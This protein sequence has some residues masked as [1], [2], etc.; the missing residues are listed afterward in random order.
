M[1]RPADD[2]LA[3]LAPA[4][5]RQSVGAEPEGGV[6]RC[7]EDRRTAAGAFAC[8]AAPPRLTR[9]SEWWEPRLRREQRR[10]PSKSSCMHNVVA[11]IST[12]AAQPLPAVSAPAQAASSP[13]LP[14]DAPQGPVIAQT[15]QPIINLPAP[16]KLEW[17]ELQGVWPSIAAVI[18]VVLTGISLHCSA[19]L[20][21]VD[22]TRWLSSPS[23][24]AVSSGAPPLVVRL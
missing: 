5:G 7:G 3:A 19:S 17:Y 16:Q 13:A 22:A 14:A 6:D 12:A 10:P 20:R 21:G 15:I 11:M 4:E 8:E 18:A 9:S 24:E 23:R 2:R 1:K